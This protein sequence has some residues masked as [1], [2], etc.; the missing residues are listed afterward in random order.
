MA[1]NALLRN[2]CTRLHE[3]YVAQRAPT[4]LKLFKLCCSAL[5]VVPENE[6]I[7]AAHISTILCACIEAGTLEH[8]SHNH[9][10]LLRQWFRALGQA[11]NILYACVKVC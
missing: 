2:L 1:L 11:S 8:E 10:A 5:S 3:L 6:A 4:L 7:A 9:F